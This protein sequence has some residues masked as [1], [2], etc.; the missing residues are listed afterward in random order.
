[1]T[2]TQI[3]DCGLRIEEEQSRFLNPQFSI[4]NRREGGRA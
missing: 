4:L 1:M 2:L 3:E